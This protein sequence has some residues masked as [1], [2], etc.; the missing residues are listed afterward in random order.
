MKK[1][2]EKRVYKRKIETAMPLC[3]EILDPQ[4]GQILYVN[5]SVH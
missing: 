5:K 2:K 3:H 4:Q 1:K